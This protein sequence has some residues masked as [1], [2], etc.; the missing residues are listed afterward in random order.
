[1]IRVCI[2][3]T[4]DVLRGKIEKLKA[5]TP[6]ADVWID[7]KGKDRPFNLETWEFAEVTCNNILKLLF[8]DGCSKEVSSVPG[9][10]SG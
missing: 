5:W 6:N 1:M 4:L 8:E 7:S 9:V 2:G 10:K 3:E